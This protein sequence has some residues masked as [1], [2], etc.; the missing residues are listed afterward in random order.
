MR[1]PLNLPTRNAEARSRCARSFGRTGPACWIMAILMMLGAI[2]PASAREA[3]V[4]WSAAP[5][6]AIVTENKTFRSGDA[7]LDGTLYL[8]GGGQAFAAVVVTHSASKP[9]R[10]ALLYQHLKEMLPPL[11][12]AVLTYD[13]RGSGRSGGN[14]KDSDY[15][16]LADD[17]IAGEAR[18]SFERTVGE[19]IPAVLDV[20]GGDA[21]RNVVEHRLQKFGGRCQ[22]AR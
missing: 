21:D 15:D 19:D 13:R 5:S 8:P 9:L 10:D 22:F 1:D 11:G 12:I 20:L 3:T 7:T 17:A 2:A 16:M 6:T 18:E 14:L 4:P